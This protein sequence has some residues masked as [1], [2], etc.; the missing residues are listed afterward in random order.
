VTEDVDGKA[1]VCL[2]SAGAVFPIMPA[3]DLAAG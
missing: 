1:T 2:R 3:D